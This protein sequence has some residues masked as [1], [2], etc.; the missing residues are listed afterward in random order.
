MFIYLVL[1]T[2]LFEISALGGTYLLVRQTP[3]GPYAP[4]LS[5][6]CFQPFLIVSITI[7][8]YR[9]PVPLL[10]A[11]VYL[12]V[13]I[14]IGLTAFV[15]ARY[16]TEMLATFRKTWKRSFVILGISLV[17]MTLASPIIVT[18]TSLAYIDWWNGEFINYSYFAQFFLGMLQDPNYI[19]GF[20]Q[21]TSLR[22][23]AEL[24][25]ATLSAITRVTPVLLIEVLAALHKLSAIISFAVCCEVLRRDYKIRP[26]AVMMAVIGFA[27]ATILSL[28]HVLAFLAAQAISA[29]L[30]MISCAALSD[31]IRSRRL[32]ILLAIHVLFVLITYAEGLPF[33]LFIAALI[34]TE[35]ILRRRMAVAWSVLTVIGIGLLVNPVLL[36][37]RFGHLYRLR[38]VVAGFNVLGNPNDDLVNYL[39]AAL[40]FHYRFVALSDPSRS[41]MT[42]GI[43]L[44]LAVIICAFAA[45]TIRYR[46]AL[47]VAVPVLLVL[48]HFQLG[49][50]G[51]PVSSAYYRSY[52]T[53]AALYFYMY[54]ALAVVFD[55]SVRWLVRRSFWKACLASCLLVSATVWITGNMIV[56]VRGSDAIKGVPT[57]YYEA[58]VY[59]ALVSA[60]GKVLVVSNDV[61]ASFWDLVATHF[62]KTRLLLDRRQAELVYHNAPI[63]LIEPTAV[64]DRAA[65]RKRTGD[66]V[67]FAGT[68]IV[69][70]IVAYVPSPVPFDIRGMLEGISPGLRLHE[71]KVIFSTPAFRVIDGE[72]I[73]V[74]DVGAAA[75][76]VENMAP[77]IGGVRPSQGS[78]EKITFSF[79]YIDPNGFGDIAA[80]LININ[81]V[82]STENGCYISYGRSANQL[83]LVRD[84]GRTWDVTTIGLG[85]GLENSQCAVD[86]ERS[87]ISASDTELT[88]RLALRFSRK[89]RG[90]KMIYTTV[91]DERK[92][93]TGWRAVGWWKV[94]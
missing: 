66:E 56:S 81:S 29:S 46:T 36:V 63:S 85:R 79:S 49:T 62:G 23:G 21:N 94:P 7:L 76:S 26:V 16:R 25:L 2:V 44:A 70:A 73:N 6:I 88:L 24:F 20:E 10:P 80:V 3:Y 78:G 28:N 35:A 61:M 55:L 1:F 43:V 12:L 31:S 27:F 22:Y 92:Q 67:L 19:P 50:A 34:T 82:D 40:G 38:K 87:S 13:L 83:G 89:F 15:V 37:Q 39:S 30:I 93:T 8:G 90:Q 72:L 59:R 53:I 60:H 11:L 57:V 69:P 77:S 84:G 71:R 33:L 18:K 42:I 48:M 14:G 64:P 52:K 74:A 51:Q 41:L 45:A 68:M 65:V 32:Q 5:L 75:E 58:D 47:F 91:A 9:R 54:L 4:L 17:S 86:A